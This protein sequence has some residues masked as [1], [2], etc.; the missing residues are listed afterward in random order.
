[1]RTVRGS[2][3]SAQCVTMNL[4]CCHKEM[5]H[6][7]LIQFYLIQMDSRL[8]FLACTLKAEV[9]LRMLATTMG[10]FFTGG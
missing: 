7:T 1:M 9:A 5:R 3:I 6:L 10:T 8:R 4:S 2:V